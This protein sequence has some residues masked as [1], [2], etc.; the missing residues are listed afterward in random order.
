M[1][2]SQPSIRGVIFDL[3]GT[4]ADTLRDLADSL[5]WALARQGLPAGSFEQI[6]GWVGDGVA[7]L[8]RRAAP[9]AGEG[10]HQQIAA[11]LA[12]RYRQHCLDTTRPFPGIES[13]IDRLRS[14]GLRT[15]V[16]SNKNHDFTV[17]I[18]EA[19]FGQGRFEVVRGYR[20]GRP[21]KPDPAVALEIARGWGLPPGDV[22]FVGDTRVD[23]ETAR[24]AG[25]RA[26]AVGW[27]FRPREELEAAQ[28]N[29]LI[30]SPDQLPAALLADAQGQGTP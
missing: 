14:A 15:G 7:M 20:D 22:A 4:L 6:R 21:R 23:V 30:D 10:A 1:Q 16:L 24:S 26:V 17:Q 11:D 13:A 25:M 8:I 28:P 18:V 27:G 3:D 19:L 5:N 12:V 9:K 2:A 29:A